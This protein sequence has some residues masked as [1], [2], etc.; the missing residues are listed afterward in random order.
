M[1]EFIEITINKEVT[2]MYNPAKDVFSK[3][4]QF[5]TYTEI[6]PN[7]KLSQ[8]VHCF[9]ELKTEKKL[10]NDFYLHV[11]PDACVNVL[12]NQ[13]TPS[14]AGITALQ[15][16]FESLNLG[17]YFHYI[18]I[19]F[20]PGVWQD[21]RE[22]I[23]NKYVNSS[24]KGELPL[25]ELSES[26]LGLSFIDKIARLS[27]FVE[28]LNFEK[29]ITSNVIIEEILSNIVN[30]RSVREMAEIANLSERQLQRVIR[31][32]TNFSPHDFLKVLRLQQSFIDDDY[33]VYYSDQS[34]YIR[35]FSKAIGYTPKEYKDK[36]NV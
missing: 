16:T 35:S 31:K 19:Q 28:W 2:S 21:R 30:I 6:K 7:N 24:Y 22:T 13:I 5:V 36:Y 15:T 26:I 12:L 9:W 29:Y 3:S 25:I 11:L 32:L 17:T 14:I 1:L 8:Y 33:L 27:K 20:L 4:V 10:T 34:H 23:L 18:G